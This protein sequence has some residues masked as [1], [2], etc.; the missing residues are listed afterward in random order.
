MEL[1]FEK[2]TKTYFAQP[3]IEAIGGQGAH[4]G[5]EIHGA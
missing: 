3:V 1:D 4:A 5:S 2:S